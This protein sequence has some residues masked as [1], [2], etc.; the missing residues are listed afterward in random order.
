MSPND[1]PSRGVASSR[2]LAV[3]AVALIVAVPAVA[4]GAPLLAGDAPTE[5][6]QSQPTDLEIDPTRADLEAEP[7]ETATVNV[8]ITN[9]G[10]S[11]ATLDPQHVVLQQAPSELPEEWVSVDVPA[12]V[13]AGESVTATVSVAVPTEVEA[14]NYYAQVAFTNVTSEGAGTISDFAHATLLSVEVDREPTVFVRSGEYLRGQ[15]QTG[16]TITRTVTVENTGEE[17]VALDPGLAED[18]GE[19]RGSGC[20]DVLPGEWLT[21]DAPEEIP[22][23]ETANVTV[24]VAP[25]ADAASA[26]YR[27]ELTLGIDDPARSDRSDYWQRIDVDVDVWS[28]PEE[29]VERTFE[30]RPGDDRVTL[31]LSAGG[32]DERPDFEV[33]FVGPEGETYEQ[34]PTSVTKQGHVDLVNRDESRLGGPGYQFTYEFE[35]PE[36]GEWTVHIMPHDTPGFGYEIVTEN[37]D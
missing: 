19:C 12:E 32:E 37:T 13:A 36:N 7:G 33:V 16:E 28:P 15:L 25:P 8:T 21:F 18:E 3:L 27:T 2:T 6:Q 24:T 9:D 35:P 17:A 14:G 34:R 4:A 10:D 29:P 5:A 22:A 26:S 23:G 31:T 1:E 20:P 11:A 30:V